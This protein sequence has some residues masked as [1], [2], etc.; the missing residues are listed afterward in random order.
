MINVLQPA[1][2]ECQPA[3]RFKRLE[4]ALRS[5]SLLNEGPSELSPTSPELVYL[6]PF[7]AMR[8][9][10]WPR[11]RVAFARANRP[12]IVWVKHADTAA[13][14]EAIKDGAQDVVAEED[15]DERWSNALTAV[16]ANQE[17]W[18]Q[19]YGGRPL[20]P[21]DVLLGRS[22]AIK[23]LQETIDRLGPT[24]VGVLIS[25][26]SGV[27]KERVASALHKAG[28]GGQFVALNC[29]AIP[30]DLLEAELFG[31]EKGAFTGAHKSRPGLVEQANGGTLFLD[32]IGE[33]DI[34][35]QPKLLRFLETRRARRVGGDAEYP[36]K[37]RVI[38]ATNRNLETEIVESRFRAD[39]YYRLAE[40]SLPVPPL[41]SRPEDITDLA[42]AFLHK[43]NERFGKHF[44][45]ME[46][47]LI[48]RF[49]QYHWPGNVRE[50]KSTVDRLV[51]L[52]DGPVMRA[53]WWDM[54]ERLA[55][56]AP[57]PAPAPTTAP[58][59]A[60]ERPPPGDAA[61]AGPGLAL[62][63]TKQKMALARKLLAESDD[64]FTWVA[65]QLGINPSTLWRWRKS[66]R[67]D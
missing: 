13:V 43:A 61:G 10:A 64:D 63:N 26:E 22:E 36:V 42:L 30:K 55:V 60:G 33:M 45:T 21:E 39:L 7:E 16:A 15:T 18:L 41:R 38:S 29:A 54:P 53:L 12:Y 44:L 8:A 1:E 27:G 62:P 6:L 56:P 31:V 20:G 50:L 47:E 65:G 51:L 37:V 46:P 66:G 59:P 67:L 49:Q 24:D 9:A 40:I 52:F 19:L 28:R 3:G 48:A 5:F 17:L 25:G 2:F 57:A 32:E 58:G 23:R 14:V 11:L 34:G 4:I 35:V